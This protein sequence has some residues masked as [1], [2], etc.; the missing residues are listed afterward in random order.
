MG[1]DFAPLLMNHNWKGNIRELKNV[2]ERVVI[3]NDGKELDPSLLPYEFHQ[4]S[5]EGDQM[6]ME[7]VE[8]LH[9]MKVL[10]YTRNNKTETARLLGIGLTTLYRK[11]EEYHIN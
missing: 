11:L 6:K 2:I 4:G 8:K 7:T 9:I 5:A 3:L 10:K 1:D